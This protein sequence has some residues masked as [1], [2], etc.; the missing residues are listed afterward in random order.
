MLAA[1]R[2][3][4]NKN[5]NQTPA[6]ASGQTAPSPQTTAPVAHQFSLD[7]LPAFFDT[8]KQSHDDLQ[9]ELL[10][11]FLRDLQDK[12]LSVPKQCLALL[13]KEKNRLQEMLKTHNFLTLMT[14]FQQQLQEKV[15]AHNATCDRL[16]QATSR[17]EA[18][19]EA[20]N[21]LDAEYNAR[22]LDFISDTL[23]VID[24]IIHLEATAVQTN[25]NLPE[26][27]KTC[28]EVWLIWTKLAK[29]IRLHTLDVLAGA[30]SS[31]TLNNLKTYLSDMC[32][33]LDIKLNTFRDSLQ[34]INS[35]EQRHIISF[36]EISRLMK[37]ISKERY[38]D[39]CKGL[40]FD[41]LVKTVICFVDFCYKQQTNL[42]EALAKFFKEGGAEPKLEIFSLLSQLD[43]FISQ[44]VELFQDKN[45][46]E[47]LVFDKNQLIKKL[48]EGY[49]SLLRDQTRLLNRRGKTI[50]QRIE[51]TVPRSKSQYLSV[52]T[53][54]P[55]PINSR[56]QNAVNFPPLPRRQDLAAK[57][58]SLH[59]STAPLSSLM[60]DL[61]KGEAWYASK[62]EFYRLGLKYLLE[63]AQFGKKQKLSLC[64]F[65]KAIDKIIE[66]QYDCVTFSSWQPLSVFLKKT[67]KDRNTLVDK[68]AAA[69]Q[70]LIDFSQGQQN[71]D[72]K[73][74]LVDPELEPLIEPLYGRIIALE[75]TLASVLEKYV[76]H[77][78]KAFK[79]LHENRV[80]INPESLLEFRC[81]ITGNLPKIPVAIFDEKNNR[82]LFDYETLKKH[83]RPDPSDASRLINPCNSMH[84]F[85]MNDIVPA[86]D[87]TIRLEALITEAKQAP[88]SDV[89]TADD[90]SN[91][92]PTAAISDQAT[93]SCVFSSAETFVAPGGTCN[94]TR[95]TH[96]NASY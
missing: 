92:S 68:L 96:F 42:T 86:H 6:T 57:E 94:F 3:L 55:L 34:G 74:W 62:S 84:T 80:K 93:S 14:D 78:N 10:T 23:S 20:N 67:S 44:N 19:E 89:T 95:R 87:I 54:T 75:P 72:K 36:I 13:E 32:A 9:E 21:K 46:C 60:N 5:K 30:K 12:S 82:Y 50:A 73:L 43:T 39:Y 25:S 41:D 53:K 77:C 31:S 76:A 18:L 2:K 11:R 65:G 85:T 22:N 83:A 26:A 1:I 59:A 27:I 37:L 35:L 56:F 40:E 70:N 48:Q 88:L 33:S 38:P 79:P 17:V 24:Q 7:R 58:E 69:L 8:F 4:L 90:N 16:M 64:D 47:N 15:D 51:E 71:L 28:R 29:N 52:S 81:E 66:K 63:E 91:I 61:S 45:I 49:R